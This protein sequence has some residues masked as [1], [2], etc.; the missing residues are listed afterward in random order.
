MKAS[1]ITIG[2]EILI[3]QTL[4]TN[5]WYLAKQ[6]DSLGFQV[7]EILTIA[8]TDMAI[9]NAMQCSLSKVDLVVLTG[10]LGPTNDDV[11]RDVFCDFFDDYLIEDPI[12]LK[13]VESLLY[14]L[15]KKPLS[16]IN[17]KQALVPSKAEIFFNSVGTAPGML[18]RK[19]NTTFIS[20]PGVPFEMKTIFDKEVS[21]YLRRNFS[22][23]FMVHRTLV[24]YGIAESLL[25][26]K[27]VSWEGN[28]PKSVKLAYLPSPGVV[29]LRLSCK[30]KDKN[31]LEDLLDDVVQLIP[32]EV[33]EYVLAYHDVD[34]SEIIC[35]EL[36]NRNKTISFA[37]S[38]TGG[39]LSVLFNS[40]AGS[41]A[42]FKG[43]IVSYATQS[44][45]DVLGVDKHL[46]DTYSVV[47][48]QVAVQMAK[49][50][51]ELLK[52]D[53]AIATT[54]NAGP[55]KGDS[56]QEVGTVF[57]GVATPSKVFA[58]KYQFI[59]SREMVVNSAVSKGLE[60]IYKEIIKK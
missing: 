58:N 48:E 3:G 37:E 28:L 46:I 43:A 15:F 53:F 32:N 9:S 44:K 50:A 10:G 60:L 23:Q 34:I 33:L 21:P 6:L 41:S 57:I 54:G 8:D 36:Q 39:K 16:S 1:I 52:S 59:G 45:I 26:E 51:Q 55:N 35:K 19:E 4:D 18:M 13:Q 25:A 14:K 29:K 5:S 12:V 47:S 31:T 40:K 22:G 11:T 2:D 20:L 49:K 56:D 17:K 30:G 42:Y 38:C 27:L 7:E 24:T